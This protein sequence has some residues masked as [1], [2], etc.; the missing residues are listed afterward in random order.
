MFKSNTKLSKGNLIKYKVVFDG[1]TLVDKNVRDWQI[2]DLIEE[3]VAD[4]NPTSIDW[5]IIMEEAE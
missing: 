5:K 1:Y 4:K 2:S 3:I